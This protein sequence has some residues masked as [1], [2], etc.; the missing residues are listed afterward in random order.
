MGTSRD[1]MLKPS[2]SGPVGGELKRAGHI[3]ESAPVHTIKL[4]C[5]SSYSA[6]TVLKVCELN[7]DNTG[8][9]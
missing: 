3:K 2:P 4:L 1:V 8:V 5:L 6:D 9:V 7:L